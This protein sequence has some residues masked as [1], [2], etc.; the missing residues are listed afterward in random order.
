[1]GK[2][3]SIFARHAGDFQFQKQAGMQILH[4]RLDRGEAIV[5]QD[6]VAMHLPNPGKHTLDIEYS[7]P[8]AR[9]ILWFP[10]Q[11]GVDTAFYCEAW[12][13]CDVDPAQR[14]TLTLEV[15]VPESTG[16]TVV[17]PGQFQKRWTDK[18]GVHFLFDQ[19]APVQTYLFSFGVAKLYRSDRGQFVLYSPDPKFH[20]H[21]LQDTARAYAFLRA[22]AGIGLQGK[23][24]QAVMPNSI[25]QEAAALALMPSDFLHNLEDKNDDGLLAH[26][27]AHQWWGVLVG[28]RSWSV[29]G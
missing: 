13:V 24:T 10:E 11:P 25:A 21:A 28:I 12:M 3:P 7:A 29:S 5:N 15:V 22:K 4:A 16:L 8:Q 9:G 18:D 19:T 26:E 2:K 6:S 14:A 17:G 1:M 20:I 23:Y 27:L